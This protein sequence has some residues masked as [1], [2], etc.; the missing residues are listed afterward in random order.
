MLSFL[1]DFPQWDWFCFTR[2]ETLTA[3]T[4]EWLNGLVSVHI[5][6]KYSVGEKWLIY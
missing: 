2:K 6:Q 3:F 5:A 1:N 4:D